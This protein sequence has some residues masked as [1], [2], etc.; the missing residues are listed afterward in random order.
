MTDLQLYLQISTL[1][2]NLKSEVVG[3]IEILKKKRSRKPGI[4]ERKF[5]YAK[6]FFIVKPDFDDPLQDFKDYM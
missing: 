5:G 3:F 4:K 1:P 2:E 6:D